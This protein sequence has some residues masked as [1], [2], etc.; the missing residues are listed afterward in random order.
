MLK[1]LKRPDVEIFNGD[2]ENI[3]RKI[4]EKYN[5][6]VDVLLDEIYLSDEAFNDLLKIINFSLDPWDNQIFYDKEAR[7]ILIYDEVNHYF[8]NN[9]NQLDKIKAIITA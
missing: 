5:N 7:I 9:L 2:A 4:L 6:D 1:E 8:I 3:K